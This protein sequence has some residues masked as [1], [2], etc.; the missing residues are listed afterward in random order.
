MNILPK[1]K[2][3]YQTFY[4]RMLEKIPKNLKFKDLDFYYP[5]IK[6]G[7][8][9]K[10]Y[11]GDSITVAAI[12]PKSKDKT[13]YKFNVRLNRIDTPEIRTKNET[14]KEFAIK[15][16]D[17]LSE[18]IMG[19]MVY[20]KVIN[21]DKYGRLLAEISYKKENIN[22]W[23]LNNNYAFKYDGGKKQEFQESYFNSNLHNS[24][25][26]LQI[27]L[28]SNIPVNLEI[29]LD[30]DNIENLNTK[31]LISQQNLLNNSTP[32]STPT[33]N[34]NQTTIPN[35][36]LNINKEHNPTHNTRYNANQTPRQN[37][38]YKPEEDEE[39]E[40]YLVLR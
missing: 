35:P 15:I 1:K 8:V 25:K 33:Y 20:L 40:D 39:V 36:I 29:N 37:P 17:L 31:L 27:D 16:R 10:V 34:L 4:N 2:K 3:I 32:N 7:R 13:I 23:L 6:K 30:T 26:N 11:D 18:K 19:K 24:Q 12:V 22:D 14:E 9:I 5:N 28:P 21:T 38:N